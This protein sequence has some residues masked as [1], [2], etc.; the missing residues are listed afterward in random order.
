MYLKDVTP[1]RVVP[2]LEDVKPVALPGGRCPRTGSAPPGGHDP[3]TGSSRTGYW[4][5]G[6]QFF[7]VLA[8]GTTQ[9]LSGGRCPRTGSTAGRVRVVPVAL[10]NLYFLTFKTLIIRR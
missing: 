8:I 7:G 6:H 4:P 10:I 9:P 5:Y 3:P 2:C 1:V